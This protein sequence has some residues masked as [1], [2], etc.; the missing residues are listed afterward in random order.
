M[1]AICPVKPNSMILNVY[2]GYYPQ[3]MNVGSEPDRAKVSKVIASSAQLPEEGQN[4]EPSLCLLFHL[5]YFC[6]APHLIHKSS[7]CHLIVIYPLQL[8]DW[9]SCCHSIS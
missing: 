2:L 4:S 3:K 8:Q 5:D 9:E 1:T 6:P 7:E